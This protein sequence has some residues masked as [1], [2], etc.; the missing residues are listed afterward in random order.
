[1]GYELFV[2]SGNILESTIGDRGEDPLASTR[3]MELFYDHLQA[4][5]T[6][7]GFLHIDKARSVMRRLRRIYNRIE[8]DTKE[9]DI[10]R[11]I[12]RYS[13]NHNKKP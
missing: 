2:A 11:G 9:L 13:Q 3:Q 5:I 1:M 4:T 7:I 10:L 6:D 12:L 8:L